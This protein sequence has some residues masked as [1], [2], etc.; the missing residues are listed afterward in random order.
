MKFTEAIDYIYGNP[1]KKVKRVKAP[2]LFLW[3]EKGKLKMKNT[4][5]VDF[6]EDEW[7]K[8][9]EPKE[10]EEWRKDDFYV[11]ASN[12]TGSLTGERYRTYNDA[13]AT[14]NSGFLGPDLHVC[15][16]D[17]LT[18]CFGPNEEE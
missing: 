18:E 3:V 5:E 6:Y 8:V 9:H 2:H 15:H 1:G 12:I 16:I 4:A 13:L 17:H 7:V 10:R 11:L 14:L